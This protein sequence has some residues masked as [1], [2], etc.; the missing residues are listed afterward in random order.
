MLT[1]CCIREQ[2]AQ[3]NGL[4]AYYEAETS[5]EEEVSKITGMPIYKKEKTVKVKPTVP[6][7][8]VT[9]VG[10]ADYTK[11]QAEK[12]AMLL[13]PVGAGAGAGAGGWVEGEDYDE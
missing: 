4:N 2:E 11:A 3:A 9:T 10:K 6:T 7:V 5:S 12:D 1:L 13:A 8:D